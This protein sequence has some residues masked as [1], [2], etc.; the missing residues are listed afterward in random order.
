MKVQV[1]AAKRFGKA[2]AKDT[3]GTRG[4]AGEG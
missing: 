4:S 2:S 3:P 1:G